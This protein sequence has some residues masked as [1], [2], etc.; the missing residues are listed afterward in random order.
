MVRPRVPIETWY[1]ELTACWRS[2]IRTIDAN[3]EQVEIE[4]AADSE[5]EAAASA[6]RVLDHPERYADSLMLDW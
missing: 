5:I 3:G 2:R 6:R 1:D 4:T